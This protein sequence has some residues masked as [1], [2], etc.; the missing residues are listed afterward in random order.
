MT[1][2]QKNQ[3]ETEI[4]FIISKVEFFAYVLHIFT[5]KL[6]YFGGFCLKNCEKESTKTNC[7]LKAKIFYKDKQRPPKTQIRKSFF[8]FTFEESNLHLYQFVEDAIQ[9]DSI[10]G[11]TCVKQTFLHIA[12]FVFIYKEEETCCHSNQKYRLSI[13]IL[14]NLFQKQKVFVRNFIE[15]FENFFLFK[16]N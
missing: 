6:E 7:N 8:S 10:N 2:H 5:F 12:T 15:I 16:F 11:I 14:R 13:I 9:N 1:D 4:Y 3:I